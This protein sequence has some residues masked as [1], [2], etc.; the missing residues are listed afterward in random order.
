M[1]APFIIPFNY[2]PVNS[3]NIAN[4]SYTV[5]SG[6]YARIV[7]TLTTTMSL[8][9]SSSTQGGNGSDSCIVEYWLRAGEVVTV[10]QTLNNFSTSTGNTCTSAVAVAALNINGTTVARSN[11]SGVGYNTNSGAGFIVSLTGTANVNYRYEEFFIIS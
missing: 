4:A 10:T 1:A 2:Q 7:A 11:A 8:A 9:G 3:G 5:P 6:K